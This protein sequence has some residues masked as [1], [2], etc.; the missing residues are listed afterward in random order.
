MMEDNIYKL[1]KKY[2]DDKVASSYKMLHKEI[3]ALGQKNTST[4]NDIESVVRSVVDLIRQ[5][6]SSEVE[7]EVQAALEK[8]EKNKVVEVPPSVEQKNDDNEFLTTKQVMDK[9]HLSRTTLWRL[10]RDGEL[11]P[12]NIGQK[13]LYRTSD[14]DNILNGKVK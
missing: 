6:I 7:K 11:V 8:I 9:L 5:Y 10:K 3:D 2:V 4:S 13:L 12:I 14:I 1:T